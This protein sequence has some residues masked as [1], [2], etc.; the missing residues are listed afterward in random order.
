M[1]TDLHPSPFH[2]TAAS[3]VATDQNQSLVLF[4]SA[5]LEAIG[6]SLKLLLL[7][8]FFE[9]VTGQSLN[10]ACSEPSLPVVTDEDQVQKVFY[11]IMMNWTFFCRG[12]NL[13]KK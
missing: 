3:W 11:L 1:V 5:S 6:R 4:L 2:S 8:A 9:E 12:M 13:T 7:V 10:H